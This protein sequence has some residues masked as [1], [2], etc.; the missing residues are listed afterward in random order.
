MVD[1]VRIVGRVIGGAG[2]LVA[3]AV[4]AFFIIGGKQ[5]VHLMRG[6]RLPASP[7]SLTPMS[8]L[9]YLRAA[10][11]AHD[12]GGTAEH[13]KRFDERLAGAR[14]AS[15]PCERPGA[16]DGRQGPRKNFRSAAMGQ[17]VSACPVPGPAP[18]QQA[19]WP[20]EMDLP[21]H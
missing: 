19:V 9:V 6:P 15:N 14:A 1:S 10:V 4:I 7:A 16:N 18:R 20:E 5:M 12:R 21:H 17:S 8:D 11:P 13:Y 3:G 2:I